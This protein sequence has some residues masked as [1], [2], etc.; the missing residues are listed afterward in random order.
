MAKLRLIAL[1]QHVRAEGDPEPDQFEEI[2][3]QRATDD[4]RARVEQTI[5]RNDD[6]R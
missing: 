4:L 1:S 6:Y 2:Y 5:P 3:I